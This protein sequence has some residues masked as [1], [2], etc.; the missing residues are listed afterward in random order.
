MTYNKKCC[1]ALF[2]EAEYE[3]L[4]VEAYW[5]SRVITT[6]FDNGR[7]PFSCIH[8]KE[9]HLSNNMTSYHRMFNLCKVY[10]G[11]ER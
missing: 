9:T 3:T 6:R 7:H 2:L 11:L 8:C 10:K 4:I 1:I 5:E